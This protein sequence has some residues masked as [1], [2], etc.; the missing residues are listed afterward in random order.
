MKRSQLLFFV[1]LLAMR[2]G[3]ADIAP[4][5]IYQPDGDAISITTGHRWDN[6]QHRG[7]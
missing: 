5:L 4:G 7:H 6:R 3:A 2:G 1:L